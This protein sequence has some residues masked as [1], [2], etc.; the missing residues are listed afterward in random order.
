[1]KTD[2]DRILQHL[3]KTKPRLQ[4]EFGVKTLGVF[5]SYA[6]GR[7]RKESDLDVLIEFDETIGLIHFLRLENLLS[8]SIGRKVD[9]VMKSALKPKI[10][11]RILDQVIYV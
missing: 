11:E 5:G 4:R 7:H 6:R 1:M 9:L 2:L 3:K 8:E 10:G